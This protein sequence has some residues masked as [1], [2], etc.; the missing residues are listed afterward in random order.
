MK[1]LIATDGSPSAR[2]AEELASAIEWPADTGIE[3]LA[4][5]QLAEDEIDQPAARFAAAHAAFRKEIDDRLTAFVALLA[6]PG[7]SVRARVVFG[8]PATVIVNEATELHAD[9]VV[10]GSHDRGALASF[11]LGSVAAEVVDHAP[12]PVLVARRSTLGPIV[13]GHDGSAGAMRA[14]ELVASWPFLARE[15]VRVVNV[16]PLPPSWYASLDAGTGAAIDGDLLQEVLDERRERSRR[17]AQAA[18]A[19]LTQR[20]LDARPER[21]DGAPGDGLLDAVAAAKAQLVVIGS[22]G[23]TGLTRLLLG[24]VA[25]TILYQARCSVLIVR[26]PQAGA[27]S[28]RPR[29]PAAAA[30]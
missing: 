15:T 14:E 13:L 6:R 12:C 4:V 26:E 1:V 8:R 5:D 27:T 28:P 23:N 3:V 25:R 17:I 11:A 16:T 19:R 2:H 21:Q 18:A 10:I 20:G 24:S 9:L 22:R 7:R 29:H 30:V